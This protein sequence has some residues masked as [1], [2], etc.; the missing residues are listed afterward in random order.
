MDRPSANTSCTRRSEPS[1]VSWVRTTAGRDLRLRDKVEA[2]GMPEE[3]KTR[4]I[5][6]WTG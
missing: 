6:K 5:G 1:S 3:M 2:A 4:A